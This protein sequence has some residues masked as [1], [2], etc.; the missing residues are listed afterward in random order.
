[1]YAQQLSLVETKGEVCPMHFCARCMCVE[2]ATTFLGMLT[3]CEQDPPHNYVTGDCTYLIFVWTLWDIYLHR[4]SFQG[5][6][7]FYCVFAKFARNTDSVKAF[8]EFIAHWLLQAR[9]THKAG[10]GPHLGVSQVKFIQKVVP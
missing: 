3:C 4:N 8:A 9:H 10:H 2:A 5:T 1:M 6:I 7:T